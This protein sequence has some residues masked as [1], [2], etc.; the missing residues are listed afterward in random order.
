MTTV[1]SGTVTMRAIARTLN[2]GLVPT[3]TNFT[4]IRHPVIFVCILFAIFSSVVHFSHTRY[5]CRAVWM[6]FGCS[7]Y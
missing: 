6:Q 2:I 1:N 3:K 5:H 7:V 4:S